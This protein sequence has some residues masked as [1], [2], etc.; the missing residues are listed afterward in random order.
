MKVLLCC[1]V[2]ME[3]NYLDEWIEHHI[4]LGFDKIVLYDN[5]DREGKY[6]ENSGE[7]TSV[8]DG[9]KV[10]FVEKI[11]IDG[12]GM[13]IICYNECYKNNSQSYDWLFFLDADEY[14]VT[15]GF[16]DV[17]E[18]LS[19]KIFRDYDMIHMPWKIYGDSDLVKSEGD[20]STKSRFTYLEA[21]TPL[22]S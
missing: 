19:Q 9:I 11:D 21:R 5:N 7:L 18:F 8:K 16:N 6:E 10:G 2:K 15:E 4:G 20:Y 17:K 22:L 3:N 1:I 14:F 13:Q 12:F